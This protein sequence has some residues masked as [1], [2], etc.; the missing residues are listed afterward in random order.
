MR[1]ASIQT[2]LTFYVQSDAD[3]MAEAVWTAFEQKAK[4]STK[5]VPK[6]ERVKETSLS[7]EA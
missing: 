4:V 7:E 5:S 3:E 6:P 2:T 1:H